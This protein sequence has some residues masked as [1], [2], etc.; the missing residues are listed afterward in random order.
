MCAVNVL[1]IIYFLNHYTAL[2]NF[3][4]RKEGKGMF[5]LTTPST[6][7]IYGYMASDIWL[8][9]ILISEKVNP[10]PPHGLLFPISSKGFYMHRPTQDSSYHGLCYTSR[11]ALA[12]TRIL[13][14]LQTHICGYEAP[15][16]HLL[17]AGNIQDLL[18]LLNG[19]L[20]EQ[21]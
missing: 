13:E 7:F 19:M 8:R 14:L 5:Y 17:H 2:F 21:Q 16:E 1:G 18:H 20:A 9:T 3:K 10:L 6:H 11:G 12:G 15:S 4:T